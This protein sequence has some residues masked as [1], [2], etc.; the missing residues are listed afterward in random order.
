MQLQNKQNK[1][2]RNNF[3]TLSSLKYMLNTKIIHRFF[4]TQ[5]SI[6]EKIK[7]KFTTK[8]LIDKNN[9]ASSTSNFYNEPFSR[10]TK[11]LLNFIEQILK[12]LNIE[13]ESSVDLINSELQKI[14][15]CTLH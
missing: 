15:S 10:Y 4:S 7:S 12:K 14:N 5:L 6:L 13:S 11:Q 1:N 2:K 9:T 3:I 8:E